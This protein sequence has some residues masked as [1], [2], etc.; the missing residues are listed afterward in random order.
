[1]KEKVLEIGSIVLVIVLIV[2][3]VM[4][5]KDNDNEI[6]NEENV[7][8]EN[9]VKN[10]KNI[11]VFVF[12]KESQN[13]YSGDLV[14]EEKYLI[15][16]LKEIEELEIISEEGPYGAYITSI[17]GIQQSDGFYWT[18]YI[19]EDYA[20]VGVSGCEIEDGKTYNFKIEEMN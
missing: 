5:T 8:N 7:N 13:I 17:N 14:T 1:M 9:I 6:P 10:E 4:L 15:D 19:G 2:V 12:N 3:G 18:Y 16:A 20:V 11:S